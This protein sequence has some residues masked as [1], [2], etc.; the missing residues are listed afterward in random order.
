MKL[1]FGYFFEAIKRFPK[2]F[3]LSF[4][5]IVGVTF[6]GT[7]VPYALRLFLEVVIATENYTTYFVGLILFFIYLLIKTYANICW[8]V[9][10]DRFGGRYIEDLTLRCI[11][12]LSSTSMKNI[13]EIQVNPIKHILYSDILDVF[14]IIGHHVP[15]IIGSIAVVIISLVLAFYYSFTVS[16]FILISLMLGVTLSFSS[17]KI[18]AKNGGLTNRSLKMHNSTCNQFVDSLPLVQTNNIIDYFTGKASG[19]IRDFINT[20]TR[21]DKK[22]YLWT[23]M[24]QNFNTLF[25]IALSAL[26]ALPIAGGSIVN[27]IFFTTLAGMIMNEGQKI[28]QLLQQTV[29][30][31]VSFANVKRILNLP[32]RQNGVELDAIHE[33]SFIHVGFSYSEKSSRVLSDLTVTINRGEVIHLSG[34]NGSGKSTLIRLIMGL[35]PPTTGMIALNGKPISA[36]SQKSINREIL[37]I[38]QDEILLNESVKKYLELICNE[39]ISTEQMSDLLA[40]MDMKCDMPDVENHGLSLSVGQRKK[41]LLMKLALRY[42]S[43]SV[44]VLDELGAGLDG[45]S[46]KQYYDMINAL[47]QKHDKIFIIT[48]HDQTIPIHFNQT[49]TI[50]QYNMNQSKGDVS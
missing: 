34:P 46:K 24:V 10:L 30:A 14:R 44:V 33:I 22:I 20:T 32:A 28:E 13:D 37:Y 48:D 25:T 9:S 38:N 19:S 43:A 5:I 3:L 47:I 31:H 27:L 39:K 4:S 42:T 18:I 21:E 41:I 26:L 45:E 11:R 49:L 36:Y 2:Q 29:K 50:T 40:S 23:G 17:R 7:F 35:Y 12:S 8:Y 15:A 1:I 16:L 6:L